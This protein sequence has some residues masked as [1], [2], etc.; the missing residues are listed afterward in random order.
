[1][2]P[3]RFAAR[4]DR[5]SDPTFYRQGGYGVFDLLAHWNFAPGAKL[6][7]GIFNLGDRKYSLAG[8]V[9][10]VDGGSTALDR[11]TAPGRNLALSVA[12][13]W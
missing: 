13:E 3:G 4:K 8:D 10:V 2:M 12:F 11:Y 9:P 7:A 5:V 6:N 1:M